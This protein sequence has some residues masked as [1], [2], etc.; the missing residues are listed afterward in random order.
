M[1]LKLFLPLDVLFLSLDVWLG[2]NTTS[3]SAKMILLLLIE[4]KAS[5]FLA[6]RFISETTQLFTVLHKLIDH[7]SKWY[8]NRLKL[9]LLPDLN[10]FTK[11]WVSA[12]DPWR[13]I[14]SSSMMWEF[15]KSNHANN[16]K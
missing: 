16:T 8:H 12:I 7:E 13:M 15:S 11:F 5:F 6:P 10:K 2:Y 4:N 3:F 9:N 1:I 14:W